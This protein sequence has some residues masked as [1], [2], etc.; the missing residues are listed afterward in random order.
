[1]KPV[2]KT[3]YPLILLL[4]A[5]SLVLGSCSLIEGEKEELPAAIQ[6]PVT[7]ADTLVIAEGNVVPREDAHLFFNTGGLVAE[8]LVEEGHRVSQGDVLIRLGERQSY[9]AALTAANLELVNAQKVFDDLNDKA[10]LAYNQALAD[11]R[12]AELALTLA[13][14]ELADLDTDDFQDD[15]DDAKND[16]TDAEEDLE[17]AQEEFDKYKELDKD[18]TRR[19]NAEDDLEEAQ[20]DLEQAV[21]D[22]NL[23][24]NEL[25]QARATLSLA[26]ARVDDLRR[27]VEARQD[28]PDPDELSLAGARL[29]NAKTQLNSAQAAMDRLDLTAPFDGVVVK[30]DAF[31]GER[32][33]PNQA[34][35]ILADLDTLYVE[36][37][38]L[39]ENEVVKISE[40][41][42]VI[43]AP[44]ALPELQLNGR[45]ESISQVFGERA[46]DIVYRVRISL[47]ESDPR[48]RWGMT[49]EARF[50][51]SAP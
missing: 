10:A 24:V 39:T 40:G 30:V 15:I 47:D 6:A 32:V 51:T 2:K 28:G 31:A 46:G 48:L 9:E 29:D 25:D 45:V 5:A 38:D 7:T 26:Q 20:E 12:T 19:K 42:S 13:E 37:N 17:D 8:V 18:N 21:R 36:T 41:Q 1:M 4:L 35:I 49:V 16:V 33:L 14:Q 43:L 34:V 44:D 23:L 3:Y 50:E 27:E 11:L 22:L